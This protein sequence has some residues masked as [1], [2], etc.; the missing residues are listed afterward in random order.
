MKTRILLAAML[1]LAFGSVKAQTQKEVSQYSDTIII[2]TQD[3]AEFDKLMMEYNNNLN[4]LHDSIDWKRIQEELRQASREMQR[5]YDSVDWEQFE[6][7]MEKWGAEMEKWSRKMEKWS[8]RIERRYGDRN[9]GYDNG[10]SEA[11][12]DEP[13]KD[14]PKETRPEKKS[15][16]FDSHWAGFEAGLNMPFSTPAGSQNL[17]TRPMRCWY[18]GLNIVDVGIAFEKRHIAGLFTGVGIGWN[19]YSWNNR[20]EMHYNQAEGVYA[21]LPI[22]EDKDVKNTKYGALFLQVPLMLEV[23]PTRLMYI[24]AGVTGGLRIAQWNRVRF[25]DR[26]QYKYYYSGANQFKLDA[27]FR[28]GGPNVGFFANYAILPLFSMEGMEVHPLSFGFSL[29]F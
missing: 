22:L 19:N 10:R 21:L 4:R 12:K 1:L 28:I 29:N 8:E 13:K 11:K 15:L 5:A 18:F 23:R 17:D 14:E 3:K 9:Y 27:S 26:S 7:D 2:V 16:L 24:A 6:R 25:T 20:M